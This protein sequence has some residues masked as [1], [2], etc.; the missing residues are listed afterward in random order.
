MSEQYKP[1]QFHPSLHAELVWY[2]CHPAIGTMK[3]SVEDIHIPTY[4]Y[5][6]ALN[7][8]HP[9]KKLDENRQ[10]E[11]EV[12]YTIELLNW[13][14]DTFRPKVYFAGGYERNEQTKLRDA[15]LS[16]IFATEWDNGIKRIFTEVNVHELALVSEKNLL[17]VYESWDNVYIHLSNDT[18][19]PKDLQSPW[20]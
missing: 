11:M 10:D 19:I 4:E 13:F 20:T 18:D 8:E 1:G 15:G 7:I 5:I 3:C 16:S 6:K 14:S 9:W 12:Q 17:A 2:R